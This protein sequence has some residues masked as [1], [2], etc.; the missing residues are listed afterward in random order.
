LDH[1]CEVLPVGAEQAEQAERQDGDG[2]SFARC[3]L[4]SLGPEMEGEVLLSFSGAP[5]GRPTAAWRPRCLEHALSDSD[6]TVA[7]V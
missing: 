4:V 5:G 7:A 2:E 3:V 6:L 1:N